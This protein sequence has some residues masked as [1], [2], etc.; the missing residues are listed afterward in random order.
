MSEQPDAS[1]AP[2]DPFTVMHVSRVAVIE[3]IRGYRAAGGTWPEVLTAQAAVFLAS[4][5]AN[6][7]ADG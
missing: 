1:Q 3:N 6:G 2:P 5:L 7:D 4:Y